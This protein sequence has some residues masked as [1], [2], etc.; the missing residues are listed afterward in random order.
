[1]L[2]GG[3]GAAAIVLTSAKLRRGGR[4][5][6]AGGGLRPVS[7][8]LMPGFR[9]LTIP[10]ITVR[11]AQRPRGRRLGP[12]DIDVAEVHDAFIIAELLYYEASVFAPR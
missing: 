8:R 1:M 11:A 10:E 2:P 6:H 3:D 4:R 9:D 5:R 7:G 12:D